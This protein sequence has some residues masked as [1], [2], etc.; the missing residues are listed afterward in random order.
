MGDPYA[1]KQKDYPLGE[2]KDFYSGSYRLYVAVQWLTEY[3]NYQSR[4]QWNHEVFKNYNR[5]YLRETKPY[6]VRDLQP[7]GDLFKYPDTY[8][9]F[10]LR[11]D[12]LRM[13]TLGLGSEDKTD[14]RIQLA[15]SLLIEKQQ[16]I[17]AKHPC[18]ALTLSDL[19]TLYC[20]KDVQNYPKALRLQEEAL[21]ILIATGSQ[22]AIQI[23]A[24]QLSHIYFLQRQDAKRTKDAPSAYFEQLLTWNQRE[25]ASIEP[26]LGS[27]AFEVKCA[28]NEGRELEKERQKAVRREAWAKMDSIFNAMTD[29]EKSALR[30]RFSDSRN[31]RGFEYR[32]HYIRAA[33]A[34]RQYLND[35]EQTFGKAVCD[36]LVF[37]CLNG[38]YTSTSEDTI[39]IS[40]VVNKVFEKT[41]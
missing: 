20:Q 32:H 6:D 8:A 35:L 40:H 5:F 38:W 39:R 36:T 16:T 7:L 12:S 13:D 34:E 31:S 9:Y 41:F 18:Y 11:D 19:A 29:S 2:S 25:I 4:A 37:S 10:S 14:W 21:N 23:A 15:D 33:M 24:M 28:R 26:C 17:G 22:Q 1:P 30:K 27:N 3:K